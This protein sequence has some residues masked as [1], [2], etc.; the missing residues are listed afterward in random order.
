MLMKFLSALAQRRGREEAFPVRPDQARLDADTDDGARTG[1]SP[2]PVAGQEGFQCRGPHRG[3]LPQQVLE[4]GVV[5]HQF[6]PAR[7]IVDSVGGGGDL[8][9]LTYNYGYQRFET[10]VQLITIAI[11]V[12][13]I[14]LIQMLRD[15]VIHRVDHR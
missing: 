7:E 3:L 6:H 9:R 13:M 2:Q 4:P 5:V 1:A 10:S 15:V 12:G 11:L 8:G 14:Q